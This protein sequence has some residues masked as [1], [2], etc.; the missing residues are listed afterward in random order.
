MAGNYG[1]NSIPTTPIGGTDLF[2][3]AATTYRNYECSTIVV[4]AD[5][6]NYTINGETF[7]LSDAGSESVGTSID[8]VVKPVSLTSAPVGVYFLCYE[9]SGCDINAFSGDTAP[10]VYSYSGATSN[11]PTIIGGDGL[12]N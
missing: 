2:T 3:S 7:V 4:S 1:G 11:R 10:S 5:T 6:A 12:R 8:L 9:C